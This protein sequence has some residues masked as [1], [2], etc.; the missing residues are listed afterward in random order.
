MRLDT[1][2]FTNIRNHRETELFFSK[3]INVFFGLNGAGKTS[4]LEAI[5]LASI[6]KSF[7]NTPENSL[8]NFNQEKFLAR[9]RAIRDRG[10]DFTIEITK[11]TGGR[12]KIT[13]SF[14]DNM[15][16]KDLIGS[17]PIIILSPDYKEITAGSPENRRRFVN[18]TISQISNNYLSDLFSYRK[19]LKQRN[20]L[21]QKYK[22]EKYLDQDEFN[23]WTNKLI[24]YGTKIVNKR[25]E[26]ITQ[27]EPYF[28]KN[29][30]IVSDRK[31]KVQIIYKPYGFDDLKYKEL[32]KEMIFEKLNKLSLEKRKGELTRFTTLFGP[33]KDEIELLIN[34]FL[35]KDTASQGQHKTVLISLKLAEFDYMKEVLN[36]TPVV[37]LDDIFS[38]LDSKRTELVI[39]RILNNLAQAFITITEDDKI[40]NIMQPSEECFYFYV[41]NGEVQLIEEEI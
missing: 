36:E 41:N 38:E 2:Y 14:M 5:S 35:V 19:I 24:E 40:K 13:S 12:K 11:V 17:L 28:S 33:Q 8:I 3:H 21:L 30:D 26:F 4:I 27:F 6:S 31:E 16:P 18:T 29:Y 37:L 7:L 10:T 23:I 1:L 25:A 39:K 9:V 15:R 34:N 22:K 32:D 20:S